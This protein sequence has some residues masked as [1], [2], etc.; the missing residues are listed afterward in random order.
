MYNEFA[1]IPV[2]LRN[3]IST[4]T[5]INVVDSVVLIIDMFILFGIILICLLR[6]SVPLMQELSVIFVFIGCH[7]LF[8]CTYLHNMTEALTETG[9]VLQLAFQTMFT[10]LLIMQYYSIQNRRQLVQDAEELQRLRMQME[11]NEQY[12]RLAES[13]FS[14]ISRLRHD[15]HAQVQTVSALLSDPDGRE[16]AEKIIDSI[17]ERLELTRLPSFCENPT[18]NA[19][20]HVKLD[21]PRF[22]ALRTEILLR[23]CGALPFDDYDLCSLISNLF[24]NAAESCLRAEH[25]LPAEGPHISLRS[26]IRSGVF[27]VRC[28]NHCPEPSQISQKQ[29]A[30]HGYGKA[31]IRS[32][33]EKYDGDY[34]LRF[35]GG[36]AIATVS[37][38]IAEPQT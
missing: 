15:I 10:T 26:G 4:F 2:I 21:D 23:D 28:V 38:Q 1:I 18:L 11:S 36:K 25:P 16:R 19:V 32:I 12:Y 22:H 8:L 20:L 5:G 30:G 24:D 3:K 14:E 27:V 29:E 7:F 31:I 17:Q 33:C 9:V 6:R 37:M 13:K 35:E 34:S